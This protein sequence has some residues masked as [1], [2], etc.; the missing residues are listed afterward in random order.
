MDVLRKTLSRPEMDASR[1]LS[2]S[3][4]CGAAAGARNYATAPPALR[5]LTGSARLLSGPAPYLTPASS[6]V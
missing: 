4:L 6:Q 2:P 3:L 1:R 5:A